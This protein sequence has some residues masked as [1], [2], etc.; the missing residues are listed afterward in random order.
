MRVGPVVSRRRLRLVDRRRSA[1]S[2]TA[3]LQLPAHEHH[4]LILGELAALDDLVPAG[5]LLL[6]DTSILLLQA[7]AVLGAQQ[8]HAQTAEPIVAECSFTGIGTGPKEMVRAAMER[9]ALAPPA[10]VPRHCDAPGL[11]YRP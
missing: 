2:R 8:M 7:R 5:D 3:P 9:A 11:K 1:G 4:I 6:R 10:Q